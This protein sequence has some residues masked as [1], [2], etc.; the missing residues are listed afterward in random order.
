MN[1]FLIHFLI[2]PLFVSY[3]F[4]A[5]YYVSQNGSD[6]GDGNYSNPFKTIAKAASVANPGDICLIKGGI[7][8]ETI[9]PL[10]SGTASSPIVFK[11][12]P[13]DSVFIS[14]CDTAGIWSKYSE[15][16]FVTDWPDT[17][18]Q[19]FIDGI[20]ANQA[21]YPNSGINL[22]S[23]ATFEVTM[24]DSEARSDALN[25]AEN[26]WK[27]GTIWAML[28]YRWVA[29]VA[30]IT[31]SQPGKLTLTGNTWVDNKGDG[32]AY[33]TGIKAALDTAGE[34]HYEN[35]KLYIQLKAGDNPGLHKIEIKSRKWTIDM[36]SKRHI[37][38]KDIST[39]GGGV[40]MNKSDHC[41][42]DNLSMRYMSHFVNIKSGGSSWIRHEWT[43][44]N[45]DGIGVG[46]F[47]SDNMIKNCEIAWSAGDGIT[48]YGSNNKIVNCLIHDC[49]YSGSDCNPVTANGPGHIITRSTIYNGGRGLI[50]FSYTEQVKITYNHCYNASLLNWDVG[51]IYAWGTDAKRAV[52][53]YNWVHDI[54]SGGVY[55]I[56]NGIYV[57][58]YCSDITIHHNV[59]WN[60]SYNAFNYSRPAKNIYFFNNTAFSSLDVTSSYIPEGAPDTSYGNLMYNNLLGFSLSEFPA[61]EQKNNLTMSTLPLH[62]IASYDFRIHDDAIGIINSGIQI[63]GI[64]DGFSGDAP[65]IGAYENGGVFWKAGFGTTDTIPI[66]VISKRKVEKYH[67]TI[68]KFSCTSADVILKISE[69]FSG[70]IKLITPQGRV[71]SMIFQGNFTKGTYRFSLNPL[72]LTRGI[73]IL[74]LQNNKEK[75]NLNLGKLIY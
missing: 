74:V 2:L 20:P 36:S 34:W 18:T 14:A 40:N 55:K 28:D 51:G 38:I 73:Y 31:A 41:T 9:K 33:I 46:V 72:F 26:F 37:E 42:L 39:F 32:I 70:N 61:L 62:D 69:P 17:V 21:R 16:V 10:K 59:I 4:A 54:I 7:Y 63:N 25:Q 56:G 60:C 30:T 12:V 3:S 64:T 22:F 58:N 71:A 67:Q 68:D 53:A 50:C 15:N 8:R 43:N 65:D 11:A 1:K 57:D 47:G 13:A 48:L 24:S 5:S 29:Q 66:G 27:G 19:L 52:I 45:Y 44:I 35:G 49:N 6:S 23:P 75:S